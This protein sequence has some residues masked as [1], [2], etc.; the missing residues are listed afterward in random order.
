PCACQ[1][2]TVARSGMALLMDADSVAACGEQPAC[3]PERTRPA[4]FAWCAWRVVGC[5]CGAAARFVREEIAMP[6]LR[7]SVRSV[8]HAAVAAAALACAGALAASS[9]SE[10]GLLDPGPPPF[11][12]RQSLF[13]GYA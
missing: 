7:L 8:L 5:R 12:F 1:R 2:G 4:A 3:G 6:L 10:S 11:A 13:S 9:D